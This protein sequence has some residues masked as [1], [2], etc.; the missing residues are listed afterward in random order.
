[1][2]RLNY[3]EIFKQ[4]MQDKNV[5]STLADF[6]VYCFDNCIE[7]E[8]VMVDKFKNNK[9]LVQIIDERITTLATSAETKSKFTR[10][11][12]EGNN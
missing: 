7:L 11:I 4:V 1:M 10:Q 2:L 9:Q 3:S 8:E 5:K 12:R 6:I